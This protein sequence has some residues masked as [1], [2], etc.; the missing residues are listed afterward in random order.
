MIIHDLHITTHGAP[1]ISQPQHH[2]EPHMGWGT[3]ISI[4]VF[5]LEVIKNEMEKGG[6]A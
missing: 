3:L 1:S 5:I 6:D 2:K 4:V